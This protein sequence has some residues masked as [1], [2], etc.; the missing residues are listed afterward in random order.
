MG[1]VAGSG[2]HRS[3]RRARRRKTE[4]LAQRADFLIQTGR[5]PAPRRILA[6]SYKRDSAANLARRVATRIPELAG[7]LVSL[8]F[9]AFTKGL[10]D[11]FRSA[12][13]SA[14]AING[15]YDLRFWSARAQGDF[16]TSLAARSPSQLSY[17]VHSLPRGTF[18]AEV[19]GTWPL[20][21]DPT[22]APATGREF[23]ASS[24]W[25]EHY[26]RFGTQMVDFTMLNRLAEL[27]V[28][29]TP[30]LRR[31]V[32]ITYPFVFVDEFQDTTGAQFSFLHSVFGGSAIITAV[33]DRKQRIMGFAGALDDALD[34][35]V[36][37]FD[38][39]TYELTWNFRS[40]VELVVLQHII[41]SRLDPSVV[42]AVSKAEVEDGHVAASLWT[43][44]NPDREAIHIAEW[45]AS[46][47][48]NTGRRAADFALV[49]RQKVADLEGRLAVAL[50]AHGIGLRNDD[51]LYGTTRLQDLL[52]HEVTRLVLGVLRLA[53]APRGLG[54][55]WLE[56]R[57][58]LGRMR[59]LVSDDASDRE[60]SDELADF[61]RELRRWLNA[62]PVADIDAGEV[63]ARAAAVLGTDQLNAFVKSQHRGEDADQLLDSLARRLADV[64]PGADN[65]ARVFADVEARDAA[66]LLT[67]HR[68]K[69]LEYHTVFFL[70]LDD[71][72]WWSY[73]YDVDEATSAFFVGLSSA[74]QRIIFTSTT[75]G[76][77]SS[78]IADLYRML[79][80]ARVAETSWD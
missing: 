42:E 21:A 65:W 28:R 25:A 22:T 31:A 26:L 48:A 20:P 60:L 1:C 44:S 36:A 76:A 34:R 80:A 37:D 49:A 51:A 30:Q 11:R 18:I 47:I 24:W 39:K 4:F 10:V 53:A 75:F 66:T 57:A 32:R 40:S 52:K 9:D 71:V 61:T 73:R 58:A 2:L 13:P 67:I 62:T 6:I 74:A 12:L 14:W 63:V 35:Y 33:G 68:S 8:T 7:R 41:A 17:G 70:G 38:A 54:D 72:Q 56:T 16:V 77:R 55:V 43:Y 23:A 46:D 19:V 64:M 79:D 59:G 3:R 5:C 78:D 15:T 29:A 50:A 45:I 27:I 69:G